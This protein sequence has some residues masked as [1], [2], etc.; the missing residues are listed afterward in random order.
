MQIQVRWNVI[1]PHSRTFSEVSSEMFFFY[2]LRKTSVRKDLCL[3]HERPENVF[4]RS[5]S[6]L[7]CAPPNEVTY[8]EQSAGR[9][10]VK[11]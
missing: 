2:G 10:A 4:L 7:S 3:I 6:V 8:A 5:Q 1:G 11:G 9:L